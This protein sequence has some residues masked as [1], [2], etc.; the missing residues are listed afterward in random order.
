LNDPS[1]AVAV[2][3]VD[4]L[5]ESCRQKYRLP[6]QAHGLHARAARGGGFGMTTLRGLDV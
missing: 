6:A 2:V 3:A 5:L 1:G 4:R